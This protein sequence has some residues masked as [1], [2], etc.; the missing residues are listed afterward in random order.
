MMRFTLLALLAI[1]CK[2]KS[3][4]PAGVPDGEGNCVLDDSDTDD[5]FNFGTDTDTRTDNGSGTSWACLRDGAFPTDQVDDPTLR[6]TIPYAM[7]GGSADLNLGSMTVSQREVGSSHVY[8]TIPVKNV[9]PQTLCFIR[10]E[11]IALSDGEINLSVEDFDY[12]QGSV[13]DVGSLYTDTCLTAGEAGF[14]SEIIEVDF[15]LVSQAAFQLRLP[16]SVGTT[17]A[18][19]VVPSG[20]V[21]EGTDAPVVAEHDLGGPLDVSSLAR[22]LLRD[23][24]GDPIIW[25]FASADSDATLQLGGSMTFDISASGVDQA[26]SEI[27]LYTDFS[28]AARA[29]KPGTICSDGLDHDACQRQ[30]WK[31]RNTWEAARD[32]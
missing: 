4:C 12:A 22:W 8:T 15:D 3:E 10:I 17:P 1:G 26:G 13:A 32:L 28:A 20:Y 5:G 31:A 11:N 30:L 16:D 29:R 21:A 7:A 25:G 6:K 18:G 23:D 9:G 27:C 2:P 19:H 24:A 14:F